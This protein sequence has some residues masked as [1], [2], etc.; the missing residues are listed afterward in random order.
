MNLPLFDDL[1]N[2]NVLITMF[3]LI[4]WYIPIDIFCITLL[5]IFYG[6]SSTKIHRANTRMDTPVEHIHGNWPDAILRVYRWPY[7]DYNN[8]HHDFVLKMPI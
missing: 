1:Q 8:P 4:D 3:A 5:S 6:R 2:V 7:D